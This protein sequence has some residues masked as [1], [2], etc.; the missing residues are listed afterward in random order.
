MKWWIQ[1]FLINACFMSILNPGVFKLNYLWLES[2]TKYYSLIAIKLNM[3]FIITDLVVHRLGR[4]NWKP[5]PQTTNHH[6]GPCS[7]DRPHRYKTTYA[8]ARQ[9][10]FSVRQLDKVRIL[11]PTFISTFQ[12]KIRDETFGN[13]NQWFHEIFPSKEHLSYIT[14]C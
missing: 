10:E 3:L 5:Q 6:Y 2:L 12:R 9:S 7:T 14:H 4:V 13:C 11:S 1:I 8:A